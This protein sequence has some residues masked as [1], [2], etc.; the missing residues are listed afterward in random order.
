[1]PGLRGL[2]SSSTADAVL[3][4]AG[5]RQKQAPEPPTDV[6]PHEIG[7]ALRRGA[8]WALA[9]QIMVQGIRF[10]SVVLL[11]RLLTP[12]DYGAAALAVTI[13]SFSPILGDVGY[14]TALIQ[15]GTAAR[16]W[17]ST[18]CW[19]ALGAGLIGTGVVV[20]GS[21]PAA[22]ALG[23]PD[24]TPLVAV[25][26]LTLALVAAGSA[27][28]ALLSRSM[29]FGVIQVAALISATVAAVGAIVLAATGAGAWAL[30]IQQVVLAGV[31]SALFIVAA[32]WRPSF[33]FSRAAFR[34]LSKFALPYTGGSAFIVLQGVVTVL[35]VGH[36]LGVEALGTWNLSMALVVVPM[37]LVAA[38]LS[39]VVYTAFARMRESKERIAE[40]WLNGVTLL[41]AVGLPPLFALIAL[42]PDIVPLVFGPQWNSAV[43]VIQIL[44]VL[45]MSR[46]LQ[47]W[48]VAV[49]DA[50]GRPQV[51]MILCGIV[52]ASLIP[53]I[54]LGSAYGLD[55]A[56]VAYTVGAF[57]FGEI[58]AFIITTRHLDLK[59]VGCG[60][61]SASS[62]AGMWGRVPGGGVRA[63]GA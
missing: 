63:E 42:A 56:A 7:R 62:R 29:S 31:T 37:T 45:V 2:I 26:G 17:A 14:G 36:F 54:W 12:S 41:A 38:P 23:E 20:L 19:A 21:F 47:T 58:P 40:V 52:C 50:A 57:V 51:N 61:A 27:S 43:T 16:P 5:T 53:S 44:C 3:P 24:V 9:V 46:T 32:R 30:V 4:V 55:G 28:N 11:A 39:R 60:P 49:L 6:A 22:Q 59:G 35:L 10:G 8:V 1:M 18:A 13:A 48:N 33:E 34:S 15:A 25:G